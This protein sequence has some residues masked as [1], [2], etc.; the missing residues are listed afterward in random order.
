[1]HYSIGLI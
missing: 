1:V